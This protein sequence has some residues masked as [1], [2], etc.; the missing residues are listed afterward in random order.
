MASLLARADRRIVKSADEKRTTRI[1][2]SCARRSFRIQSPVDIQAQNCAVPGSGQMREAADGDFVAAA[3]TV[4]LAIN[5]KLKCDLQPG[6]P[7]AKH[8][9]AL[10]LTLTE[11]HRVITGAQRGQRLN[12]GFNRI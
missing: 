5:E 11:N 6:T 12:P 2:R 10:A 7:G 4:G 1:D 8:Q 3:Q 9:L